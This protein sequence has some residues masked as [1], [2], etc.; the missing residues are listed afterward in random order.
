MT[1]SERMCRMHWRWVV[2]AALATL[3]LI[4]V[5][6]LSDWKSALARKAVGQVARAGIEEAVEDAAEKVESA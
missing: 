1:T 3:M 6:A 5:N 2:P 4:Q